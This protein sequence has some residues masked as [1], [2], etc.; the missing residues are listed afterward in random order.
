[1]PLLDRL[2]ILTA[3]DLKTVD[4]EV[5]EWGGTVRVRAMTG[6]ARDAFGRSLIGADGKP[7]GAGYNMKL[8]A[9]SVVNEDGTQA[10]TLDDIEV[11][12]T[13]S[14]PALERVAAAADKL[15]LLAPDAVETAQGN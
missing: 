2:A 9:V 3:N 1:M 6:T 13:K 11:L 5:P 7:N 8:V 15:N 10:F 4:V 12:G 14:A